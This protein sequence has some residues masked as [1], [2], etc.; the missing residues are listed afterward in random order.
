M[1]LQSEMESWGVLLRTVTQFGGFAAMYVFYFERGSL[2]LCFSF[3]VC[4]LYCICICMHLCIYARTLVCVYACVCMCRSEGNIGCFPQS[5][6]T[7]IFSE[8]V[9][10][11]TR[12]SLIRLGWGSASSSKSAFLHPQDWDHRPQSLNLPV[13]TPRTEITDLGHYAHIFRWVLE[14][15]P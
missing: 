8:R 6:F 5:F 7:L 9:F 12:S 10:H 14:V 1:S 2:S 11:W 4:V 3:C 15:W 13:S